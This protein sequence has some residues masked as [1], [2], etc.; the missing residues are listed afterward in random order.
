MTTIFTQNIILSLS[1]LDVFAVLATGLV[2]ALVMYIVSWHYSG[3]MTSPVTKAAKMSFV[4][5][6]QF[7][8]YFLDYPVLYTDG[9]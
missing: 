6:G 5:P 8:G 1:H 2:I 7:W 4:H 3:R 9:Q